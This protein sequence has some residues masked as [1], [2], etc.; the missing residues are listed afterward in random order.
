MRIKNLELWGSLAAMVIITVFYLIYVAAA[1][2]PAASGLVGHMLGVIGFFLMLMTE[3]LYSLR[4]RYQFARW[5]K[6]KDWLS[7]HIFTGLVGPFMVLLHSSWKFNGLAGILMLMTIIIVASGFV[8]RYFYTEIPRSVDGA[9]LEIEQLNQ[10]A[11]DNQ[12]KLA[13]WEQSQPELYH[14]AKRLFSQMLNK[15][16]VQAAV[17]KQWKQMEEQLRNDDRI[18]LQNLRHFWEQQQIIDKQMSRLAAARKLLAVWHTVH[19]PLGVA[20]FT[21]AFIHIGA[22]LYYATLLR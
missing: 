3:V 22:T 7:F 13:A 14:Q 15:K 10:I 17:Q 21:V 5:G 19:I 18:V 20:M 8:G 11:M 6:L 1:E 2:V 4:K 9:E 16:M 12:Q